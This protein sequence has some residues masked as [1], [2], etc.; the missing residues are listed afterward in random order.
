MPRAL[1][2]C[3]PSFL[4]APLH[5]LQDN[6]QLEMQISG[7]LRDME[8]EAARVQTQIDDS[9]AT[10]RD[11]LGEIVEVERQASVALWGAHSV[12]VDLSCNPAAIGCTELST[13]WLSRG[14]WMLLW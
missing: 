8:G 14:C 9:R 1:A 6:L 13:R 2:P 11:T 3:L 7:D 5:L 12:G 4:P 10:K